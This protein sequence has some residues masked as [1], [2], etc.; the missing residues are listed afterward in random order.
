MDR[1]QALKKRL[2]EIIKFC[3]TGGI[4]FIIDAGLLYVLNRYVFVGHYIIDSAL[5]FTVS[6]IV[7][8]IICVKWVF[9]NVNQQDKKTIFIFI[10]T[11][12]VGLLLNAAIIKVVVELFAS[13]HIGQPNEILLDLKVIGL[14]SVMVAKVISTLIVMV[15]NYV[16]KRMAVTRQ[17]AVTEQC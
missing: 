14:D 5:S 4:C 10:A 12:V 9:E 6:V 8:Y 17:V 7:N 1:K 15:W 13:A 3:I 2:M 11:S 16:T